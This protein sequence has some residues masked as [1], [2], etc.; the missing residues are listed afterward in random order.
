M[1]D[2]KTEKE[3]PA[4]KSV[5]I[6]RKKQLLEKSFLKFLSIEKKVSIKQ[7]MIEELQKNKKAL[8][9]LIAETEIEANI[10]WESLQDAKN[11]T[12]KIKMDLEELI[13]D[14]PVGKQDTLSDNRPE[15]T[16]S[17]QYEPTCHFEPTPFKVQT[18][19]MP[20]QDGPKQTVDE[21]MP[22]H[23][24]PKQTVDKPM[25]AHDGPKQTVDVL[26]QEPWA[27]AI[28]EKLLHLCQPNKRL[29]MS[30]FL[31]ETLHF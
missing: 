28:Q 10:C 25:P 24:G 11:S 9:S 18:Q 17:A 15:S 6:K 12:D 20:A 3:A 8:N 19:P 26:C 22:A 23:D 5:K 13:N 31:N 7:Q 4:P 16:V 1:K 30:R 2:A 29:I 21:P 14:V 27:I